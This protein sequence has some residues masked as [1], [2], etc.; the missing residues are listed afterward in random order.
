M[1]ECLDFRKHVQKKATSSSCVT[2][3]GQQRP[4]KGEVEDVSL[5]QADHCE[6]GALSKNFRGCKRY[7]RTTFPS[8][9]VPRIVVQVFAPEYVVRDKT[10][11]TAAPVAR[12]EKVV[13]VSGDKLAEHLFQCKKGI[14]KSPYAVYKKDKD[15]ICQIVL[16]KPLTVPG[17]YSFTVK[18][19]AAVEGKSADPQEEKVVEWF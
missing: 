9:L 16:S 3:H 6:A 2:S 11:F 10:Y 14:P 1:W 17:L 12:P 15:L 4:V 8:F 13:I 7:D 19:V 5:F 18:F